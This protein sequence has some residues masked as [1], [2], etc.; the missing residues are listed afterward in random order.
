MVDARSRDGVG[1]GRSR[2]VVVD[3]VVDVE[4]F[5]SDFKRIFKFK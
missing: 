5:D 4:D 3:V 2:D 1:G